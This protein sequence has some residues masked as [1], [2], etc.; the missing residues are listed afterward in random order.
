MLMQCT[1]GAHEKL[2]YV[3]PKHMAR[4]TKN[5]N[6]AWLMSQIVFW[7]QYNMTH[8]GDIWVAKPAKDW[9]AEFG[10]SR[11]EFEGAVDELVAHFGLQKKVAKSPYYQWQTTLHLRFDPQIL[12]NALEKELLCTFQNVQN[13][14][15]RMSKM[16]IPS[17]YRDKN[18]C[19]EDHTHTHTDDNNPVAIV[20]ADSSLLPFEEKRQAETTKQPVRGKKRGNV[21]PDQRPPADVNTSSHDEPITPRGFLF[22]HVK[23]AY[24]NIADGL[25]D[26]VGEQ[27][28]RGLSPEL[29]SRIHRVVDFLWDASPYQHMSDDEKSEQLKADVTRF[30]AWWGKKYDVGLP[31]KAETLG[32]HWLEFWSGQAR[33]KLQV[34]PTPTKSQEEHVVG[35]TIKRERYKP[36]I[37][38]LEFLEK[39]DEHEDQNPKTPKG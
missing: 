20:L 13:E 32:R 23:R 21:S 35:D 38:A 1:G 7:Q 28:R 3:I 4:A 2:V 17:L 19:M 11:R 9:Q 10:M 34:K 22:R 12:Y 15:S 33:A 39:D 8:H 25:T 5:L 29:A 18:I 14:H 6:M 27:G 16:S 37:S 30:V 36:D 31:E 26:R 24:F